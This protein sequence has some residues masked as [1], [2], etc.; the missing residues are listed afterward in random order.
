MKEEALEKIREAIIEAAGKHGV[1]IDKI[2]L[3]GS[4]AR[5]DNRKDSDWDILVV[6]S[7]REVG[8]QFVVEATRTLAKKGIDVHIVTVSK[9][10]YE[11][12]KN[13][14][15]DVSGMATLEGIVI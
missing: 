7:N 3:F 5:G 6:Y 2:I 11:R 4:R 8:Y 9:E 13:V 14:Y 12:F 10:R 1:E 15:G